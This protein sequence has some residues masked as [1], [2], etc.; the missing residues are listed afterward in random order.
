M[1]SRV[2]FVRPAPVKHSSHLP[3]QR[4]RGE[5]FLKEL[6]ARPQDA[7]M[8][9]RVVGVAGHVQDGECRVACGLALVELLT[10]R[11]WQDDIGERQRSVVAHLIHR[12]RGPGP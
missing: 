11:P 5:R 4:D 9:R 12:Q 3:R 10:I 6:R 2:S 7:L 8:G 1:S